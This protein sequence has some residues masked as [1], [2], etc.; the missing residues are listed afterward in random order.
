MRPQQLVFGLAAAASA[1]SLSDVCTSSYAVAALPAGALE[2]VTIDAS[3]V[4]AVATY[5]TT[6][7]GEVMY[8]DSTF[9]YCNVTVRSTQDQEDSVLSNL[10]P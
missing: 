9:D 1:T 3:S 4:T 8:P 6:I 2:S 7:T 5:N 10:Y